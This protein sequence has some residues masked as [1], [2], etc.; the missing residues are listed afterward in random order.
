[1]SHTLLLFDTC[2]QDSETVAG[3]GDEQRE[4][5]QVPIEEVGGDTAG[6]NDEGIVT[7]LS[8]E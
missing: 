4:N 7:K 6:K 3:G 2:I 8:T 1:M 5:E